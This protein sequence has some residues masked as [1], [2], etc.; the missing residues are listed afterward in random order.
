MSPHSRID[1]IARLHRHVERVLRVGDPSL[2][3][4]VGAQLNRGSCGPLRRS[5]PRKCRE[6]VRPSRRGQG[7]QC[8]KGGTADHITDRS[9]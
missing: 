5:I 7:E 1:N 4:S 9:G 3:V 8:D 6:T 2:A